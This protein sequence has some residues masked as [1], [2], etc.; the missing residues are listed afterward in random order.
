MTIKDLSARTGYSVGTVSR[1]L[2]D[3]PNVSEKARKAILEAARE[4]GFQLNTNAQQLKKQHTN[5]ILVVVKG[6]SNQLFASM[7]EAMQARIAR[8]GHPLIVDY[9]DEESNEVLHALRLCRE[10]KPLG[11]I[12]LGGN[13][14]HFE[15]DFD[16]IGRPCVLVTNSAE[17]LNFDNLSSI[18]SDNRQAARAAIDALV[19]LGHRQFALIGGD[20]EVSDTTRLRFEGCMDAFGAHGIE[21]DPELDYETVRFS[22]ADGYWAARRLMERDRKFTAIFAMSDAM[23]IGAIRALQD[24]GR[25]VPEDVSVMGFDGL[26]IGE[27]TVPRLATVCQDVDALAIHSIHMLL[28]S[29]AH[30]G[31]PRHETVPVTVTLRSSAGPAGENH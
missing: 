20:R 16:K 19:E 5:S 27:Y 30:P 23:A 11:V 4:C 2:N 29:I 6:I 10:K 12:F 31:V 18:C 1:V 26:T 8:T 3:Q 9:M 22:Y 7:V 21:F 24:R 17:G 25:R 14:T 28:E 13:R 15:A